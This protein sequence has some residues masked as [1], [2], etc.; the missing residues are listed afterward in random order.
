MVNPTV[1]E[2]PSRWDSPLDPDMSE[3]DIDRILATGP[4]ANIDPNDFPATA[5]LRDIIRND[6]RLDWYS[7]G[8]ILLRREDYGTSAYV[9]MTGKAHVILPP[10]LHD[11]LLGRA[12]MPP[13]GWWAALSQMWR[14]PLLPETRDIHVAREKETGERE[15]DRGVTRVF[16]K[17][18]AAVFE[19]HPTI[20]LG[21]GDMF[22]EITAL[23]RAQRTATIFVEGTAEILEIRG[24]GIRDLRRRSNPFRDHIDKLYRKQSLLTH[25]ERTPVFDHLD[26]TQIREVAKRTL[27]E[28]YGDFDWHLSYSRSSGLEY[29]ERLSQEPIIVREGDYPDGL[30]MVRSG[31]VRETKRVNNGEQTTRYLTRG[32]VF[33]IS[34]LY[35]NWKHP[36][37]LVEFKRT[38]RA[39]GYADI[40]CVPTSIIELLVFPALSEQST[41]NTDEVRSSQGDPGDFIDAK[42]W[43]DIDLDLLENIVENR[44]INGTAAML[45]DLDRCV[46]CDA[47][48]EAC[49]K[50]HNNN[51]RFIRHGRT[52]DH[53]MVANAC[54]HCA[55]PVCMLGCS[56]G[57]I[58]RLPESGQVVINDET[59]IGCTTCANN[60]PYDN[61]RMVEIRDEFG[62][63]VLDK[64]SNTPIIKATKCDLCIDQP[65]GPACQRACPHD[66]LGRIDFGDVNALAKWVSR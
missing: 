40:L 9:L 48:V 62:G 58:H 6:T 66:A 28:T 64:N 57:A 17:D 11:S 34:P 43:G 65:G 39:V 21:P 13:K 37:Q 35:H 4:F 44:F 42:L 59:C 8:D 22:G 31:F 19:N 52:I 41:L 12:D 56:T 15:I 49:A 1:I 54:M 51:P 53:Y 10:G 24:P 14:N 63:T 25:I 18:V 33:G 27:F 55:D 2:R 3:A 32:A 38:Y 45:I 20:P 5:S 47:C 23:D 61:I 50:G 16:L 36:D 46:R 60:C 30:F 7:N 26:K 29:G